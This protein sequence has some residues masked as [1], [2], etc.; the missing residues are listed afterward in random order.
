ML[1][2]LAA[3]VRVAFAIGIAALI[4]FLTARGV[5]IEVYIQRMVSVTHSFPLLAVPFF[6][7]AGVLMNHA[8]ITNRLMRL[9]DTLVGHMT[10]GLAQV[11]VLL[12]TLMGGMSGS[13]NADAAVQSKIM[14]PEMTERGYAPAF[15]AA[16]T[17]SSSVI[18]PI[19]PP[20]IGLVLF[21]FL[22]DV[23]I[24]RLFLA[25]IVPGVLMC[26]SLMVV[27]H[28]VSRRRGYLPVRATRA[29]WSERR[30]AIGE[31]LW[32]LGLPIVIV[33]GIRYGFFT[34]TEAGAIAV[35]YAMI[36]GMFVYRQLKLSALPK[37][38]AEAVLATSVVM[39]IICAAQSFGFYMSWERIP[40]Q[41][42]QILLAITENPLLLLLV[43][44]VFLVFVG[45]MLEGSAALILLTPLLAP[46]AIGVGIDPVHFGIVMVV[47]LTI[48]GVTPPV[49]TLI[50][51]TTGIVGVRV[52]QFV[53]E[54]LPML[55]ALFIVLLLV[56]LVPAISLTLPRL[57]M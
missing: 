28:I 6:I 52:D 16:I 53:K 29:S 41:A 33:G 51:T 9:A 47:N 54:S 1:G 25:G 42:G 24:G 50:Y 37:V 30:H 48:A 23:S 45:M 49:G 5:P 31:S 55:L 15:S 18:A 46:L 20:G 32:A 14:V 38:L 21:G 7:L 57:L 36:V 13:A 40:Q 56:T 44:N 4:F 43:I 27:V 10:G 22:A 19:I 26:V 34:P 39:L 3:N 17:A 35:L 11:N 12:S 8:G 2:L